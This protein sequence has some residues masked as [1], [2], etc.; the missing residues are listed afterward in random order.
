MADGR[1]NPEMRQLLTKINSLQECIKSMALNP[2]FVPNTY[3]HRKRY[4]ME[5]KKN[6]FTCDIDEDIVEKIM[7][8]DDIEDIW[9]LLLLMGIGVFTAHKSVRYIE[10]MKNLAHHQKLYLIIASD[11]YIYGTNYQFCHA[12]ISKDLGNISQEKL[13]Q[14]LG[15]AGRNRLQQTYSIRFRENELIEKLFT[16]QS[17]KPEVINMAKLFNT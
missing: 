12:Y 5:A 2:M 1:I 8:I 7:L 10:I 14:A 6:T 13:I 9:K 17:Y 15:R 11:D 4:G 3:E 16:T